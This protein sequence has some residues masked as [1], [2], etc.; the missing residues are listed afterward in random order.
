M[1]LQASAPSAAELAPGDEQLATHL[2]EL[3][4]LSLER[5]E[6]A[7]AEPLLLRLLEL[8]ARGGGEGSDM[9][10]VLA[11]LATVRHALGRHDSAEQLWRRVLAIRERSLA[12]NHFAITRS[13]EH[14]ADACAAQGKLEEA[15]ALLQRAVALREQTSS[16][17]AS[18][19]LSMLRTKL[20]DLR[21][22]A[23]Q[24]TARPG[25]TRVEPPVARHF[26]AAR[27]SASER[28][29]A[30]ASPQA[31]P[32]SHFV[33]MTP[34]G[35]YSD[36]EPDGDD[37]AERAG[38]SEPWQTDSALVTRS[39]WSSTTALA[40]RAREHW[41]EVAIAAATLAVVPMSIFASA[42]VGRA[43]SYIARGAIA[44]PALATGRGESTGAPTGSGASRGSTLDTASVS[45]AEAMIDPA[46]PAMPPGQS[47]TSGDDARRTE[48]SRVPAV[49]RIRRPDTKSIRL[50]DALGALESNMSKWLD[51][52]L[53][54][55]AGGALRPE[56]GGHALD[57]ASRRADGSSAAALPGGM[58]PAALA[59][60]SPMP[61][62]P[63]ALRSDGV[64]GTVLAEF[65]VDSTGRADP[66]TLE[67]LRSDNQLFTMAVRRALPNM[68][69]IPAESSGHR[70]SQRLQLPFTF[71][72][73]GR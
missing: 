13:I 23:W 28:D 25:A 55:L 42:H 45:S 49:K 5:G 53:Q 43:R 17:A 72:A 64:S 19:Q 47:A 68:R 21:L 73:G 32:A 11:S 41:R 24:E 46:Q 67:V 69:F 38:E 20:A 44:T 57:A 40:T 3:V 10:T 1:A 71:T 66:S 22:F 58:A 2:S 52:A 56:T 61:E 48:E 12:P 4:R 60:G 35:G 16:G 34:G 18:P 29:M 30:G 27:R 70:V 15:I 14:L 31:P 26:P 63:P 37:L 65:V 54:P 8:R 9:A 59:S 62:Y 36:L 33:V 7:E 39:W 51:S 50:P 6:L